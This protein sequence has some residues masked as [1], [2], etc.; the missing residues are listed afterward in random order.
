M[1]GTANLRVRYFSSTG[2]AIGLNMVSSGSIL[3]DSTFT[4]GGINLGS[5]S[6]ARRVSVI[7][8]P[9]GAAAIACSTASV[10]EDCVVQ[11]PGANGISLVNEGV[12]RNCVVYNPGGHGILVTSSQSNV[13]VEG[14][15]VYG[16]TVASSYG[17]YMSGAPG[18]AALVRNCAVGNSNVADID[19]TLQSYQK[20]G[21]VTLSADPFTNGGSGDFSLTSVAGGGA[22]CRAAG[23]GTIPGL[24][25]T[26]YRDI[27][28]YQHADPAASGQVVTRRR[29]AR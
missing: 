14:S 21:N 29:K 3:E 26:T 17:I 25:A 22:A 12:V 13:V 9:A 23:I 11:S 19:P 24:S 16:A 6:L 5:T 10:A 27:G 7:S 28:T 20:V 8:A 1:I 18:S 15:I 4:G 2:C